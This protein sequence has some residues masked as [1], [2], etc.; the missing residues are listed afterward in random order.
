MGGI[1]NIHLFLY[2]RKGPGE[3]ADVT[4]NL[5]PSDRLQFHVK[6]QMII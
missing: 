2:T 1:G 3:S 4:L 5:D 6:L